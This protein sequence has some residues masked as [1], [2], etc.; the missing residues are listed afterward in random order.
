MRIKLFFEDGNTEIVNTVENARGFTINGGKR[1]TS[2]VIMEIRE[3]EV[4][5]IFDLNNMLQPRIHSKI[6]ASYTPTAYI[7]K[8][9]EA[10][11]QKWVSEGK[12][13]VWLPLCEL[14]MENL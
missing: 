2:Y 7:C 3:E 13:D 12:E 6:D 10:I 11:Y 1:W 4:K 14:K 5:Q 8:T 9:G